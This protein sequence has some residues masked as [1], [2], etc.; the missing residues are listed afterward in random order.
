MMCLC[1][2]TQRISYT[3]GSQLTL[4]VPELTDQHD[5]TYDDGND[6]NNYIA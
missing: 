3:H 1:V 5:P 6:N 4:I 2:Y